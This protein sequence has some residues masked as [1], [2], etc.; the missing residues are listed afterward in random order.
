[1]YGQYYGGFA[2]LWYNSPIFQVLKIVVPIV[3]V[4]LIVINWNKITGFFKSIKSDDV[5]KEAVISEANII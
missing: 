5:S 2:D 1:M 3:V 4:V